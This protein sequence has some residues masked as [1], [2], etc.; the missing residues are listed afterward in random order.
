MIF[1][2]AKCLHVAITALVIVWSEVNN[3]YP[4]ESLTRLTEMFSRHLANEK[5]YLIGEE[6]TKEATYVVPSALEEI[7][8]KERWMM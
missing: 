6:E 5:S 3:F 2:T 7:C 1:E 8:A 4:W